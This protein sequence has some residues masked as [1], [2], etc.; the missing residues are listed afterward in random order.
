[1][2]DHGRGVINPAMLT[3][4]NRP[5]ELRRHL[6]GRRTAASPARKSKKYRGT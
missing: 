1:M 2:A 3:A 6:R 5:N 4:A